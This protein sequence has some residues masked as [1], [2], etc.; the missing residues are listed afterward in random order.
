MQVRLIHAA[1]DL[2]FNS[3]EPQVLRFLNDVKAHLKQAGWAAGKPGKQS[4]L[5]SQ[6]FTSDDK[7]LEL[8]WW[9]GTGNWGSSKAALSLYFRAGRGKPIDQFKVLEFQPDY[10][11]SVAMFP[12]AAAK[13]KYLKKLQEGLSWLKTKAGK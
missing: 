12:D 6:R 2:R 4:A 9:H 10:V 7:V 1:E 13:A 11:R 3:V 5:M 8:D